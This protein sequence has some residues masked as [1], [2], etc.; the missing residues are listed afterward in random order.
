MS[1][2]SFLLKKDKEGIATLILNRPEKLN[3]F[4]QE[5]VLQFPKLME[6]IQQDDEVKVLILTGEGRGFCSGSDVGRQAAR[7]AG[8]K[9]ERTRWERVEPV[10][11]FV[12]SLAKLAKPTIAAVNGIAAGLGLSLAL[13]CDIRIAAVG[14]K[15]A[16]IWIRGGLVGDCGASYYLPKVIGLSRAF[17][18]MYT[19]DQIDAAEAEKIG[20]V[21]KVVTPDELIP[22]AREMAKRLANGPSVALSL[23]KKELTGGLAREM[24]AH[25][26]FE[27]FAINLCR[28][29]EDHQEF[30]KAFMEKR[31]PEFKGR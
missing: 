6:E 25:L 15:F 24:E 7:L 8:E 27:S 11:Y 9:I 4:N 14:A 30:V 12:L 3:A 13:V 29:T 17:E 16:A 5:M 18:M 31:K 2:Q 28:Q 21:S 10:G 26:Y 1:N 20:L 19:G 23:I 22:K